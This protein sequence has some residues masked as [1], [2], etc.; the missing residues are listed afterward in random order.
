MIR[1]WKNNCIQRGITT[2]YGLTV[3]VDEYLQTGEN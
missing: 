2:I 1:V 3:D